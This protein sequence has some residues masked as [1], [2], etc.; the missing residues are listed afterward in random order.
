MRRSLGFGVRVEAP[1]HRIFDEAV[2]KHGPGVVEDGASVCLV[3]GGLLAGHLPIEADALGWPCQRA[4]ANVGLVPA[5][6]EHHAIH[7]DLDFASGQLGENFVALGLGRLAVDVLGLHAGF[8]ELVFEVDRV[9]DGGSEHHGFAPLG[10]PVPVSDHVADEFGA[11][12][13]L[14]QFGFDVVALPGVDAFEVGDGWGV[15]AGFDQKAEVDELFDLR[16]FDHGLERATEAA[17]ISPAGRCCEA[18]DLGVGSGLDDFAIGARAT[19]VRLV[20]HHDV[21]WWQSGL[22]EHATR[23]QRLH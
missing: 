7:D 14:G 10:V 8:Y 4:A 18:D 3:P 5:F 21:G 6:G 13:A 23:P 11:V 20:D 17:A 19:V 1:D 22:A 12:D 2:L 9:G 15:D 16:R